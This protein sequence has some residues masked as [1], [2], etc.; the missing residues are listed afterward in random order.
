M[1]PSMTRTKDPLVKRCPVCGTEFGA[2]VVF[3]PHDGTRLVEAATAASGQ[4]VGT[5]LPG[6]SIELNAFLFADHLGERYQGRGGDGDR[7]QL[8]I[9]VLSAAM[10]TGSEAETRLRH[11]AKALGTALPEGL[12]ELRAEGLRSPRSVA[13][14]APPYV[15]VTLD[16]AGLTLRET[17]DQTGQG[18]PWQRAMKIVCRLGRLL[19][20]MEAQ[21]A[22]LSYL[23]PAG[24]VIATVDQ[25]A[26]VIPH[27]V[28]WP[29]YQ[30]LELPAGMDHAVGRAAPANLSYLAPEVLRQGRQGTGGGGL[31]ALYGLGLL[32]FEMIAG[33]PAFA[34]KSPADVARRQLQEKHLRLTV[35]RSDLG[36]PAE[37]DD[38]LELMLA[39]DP[40][41]RFQSFHAMINAL[42]FLLDTP[43]DQVAPPLASSAQAAANTVELNKESAGEE[44]GRKTL[45]MMP[46]VS[47]AEDDAPADEEPPSASIEAAPV[48]EPMLTPIAAA[49]AGGPVEP[50]VLDPQ[51]NGGDGAGEDPRF[52]RESSHS[53]DK[54]TLIGIS[55]RVVRD[56]MERQAQGQA[57]STRPPTAISGES[58]TTDRAPREPAP[59]ASRTATPP[60]E[61]SHTFGQSATSALSEAAVERADVFPSMELEN[62][63]PAREG[64]EQAPVAIEQHDESQKPVLGEAAVLAAPVPA[65]RFDA[66]AIGYTEPA[67]GV[68]G[69]DDWFQNSTEDAWDAADY[70]ERHQRSE[71][72]SLTIR[73]ALITLGFL[74]A[75]GS[76]V[77]FQYLYEDAEDPSTVQ[78]EA[79]TE[80]PEEALSPEDLDR[81]QGNFQTAL[82]DGR[83]IAPL[84]N[85]A[86]G[87]LR[88][89]QRHAPPEVYEPARR[90]F[91]ARATL[92]AQEAERVEQYDSARSLAGYA[93]QFAPDNEELRTYA[94][95]LQTR[96]LKQ[97]EQATSAPEAPAP[98][99]ADKDGSSRGATN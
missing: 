87:Y 64:E 93:Q 55:T 91:V 71:T 12:A 72:N 32:L 42:S 45:L 47:L 86:V 46:A 95:D 1:L 66:K 54:K 81:L 21:G 80:E 83:L 70:L 53:E 3:C 69:T 14:D 23:D 65:P 63:A 58:R 61:S 4:H 13:G 17:L 78:L 24:V 33:T 31:Q 85:S 49:A 25:G 97:R 41:R 52:A 56:E 76:F 62:E 35:A 96:W 11:A 6:V 2:A 15:A 20:W 59:A 26:D 43:A 67:G 74:I 98:P 34:A 68:A 10:P 29:L 39:K 90:T 5:R 38:L 30:L 48:T 22:P 82:S 28:D 18:L 88:D 60:A 50:V 75:L 16:A 57:S 40:A 77:Y 73:I 92:A 9:T 7:E 8:R 19:E 84:Q 36:L 89:L 99:A 37:I 27:L 79:T 94:D 44:T 51:E